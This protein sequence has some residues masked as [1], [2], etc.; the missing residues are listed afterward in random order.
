MEL[1]E[2]IS[3]IK[4][5]DRNKWSL[6]DINEKYSNYISEIAQFDEKLLSYYLNTIKQSEILNNQQSEVESSLL[7]SLYKNMHRVNSIDKIIKLLSEQDNLTKENLQCLHKTL[8]AGTTSEANGYNFRSDNNKFVGTIN[9]DGSKRID[10]IPVDYK[11]IPENMDKAL[12]FL[13]N[14]KID[15]VFINPI[16]FHGVIAAMQPF[17]DGNTRL[18][19]LVQHAKI[20]KNTNHLYAKDFKAPLIYLSKNYLIT[21]GKYRKLINHLAIE[22]NNEAWNQWISYNLN[23]VDEQLYYLNSSIELI[24]KRF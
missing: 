5:N 19:R 6:E 21:R 13:N 1:I 15:N 4:L 17:D 12:A 23:M 22:Q 18:S 9:P 24:K 16:V 14:N 2:R 11:E 20:W 3:E 8:M 10:Y 7:I